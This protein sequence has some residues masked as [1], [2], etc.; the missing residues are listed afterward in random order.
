MPLLL[1]PLIS[2]LVA[3]LSSAFAF[4]LRHPFVMKMMIF[5]LF[6]GF[7]TFSLNFIFDMVKPYIVHNEVIALA[8]YLGIMQAISLYITIIV[9]GFSTK[10]ILAFVRST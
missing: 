7:I 4:L 10:Q 9:A 8:S 3:F 2:P 6:L 1:A 5:T